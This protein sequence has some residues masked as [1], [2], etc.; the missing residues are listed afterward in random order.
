MRFIVIGQIG[1]DAGYW[2]WDGT[3]W[4]HVGGWGTDALADVRV[5]LTIVR[6]ASKFK[7]QGLA[8]AATKVLGDF[9]SKAVN[10]HVADAG[11]GAIAILG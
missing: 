11:K 8:D 7:T 5:A 3:H 6:E 1:S 9:L 4:R 2:Y 10:E